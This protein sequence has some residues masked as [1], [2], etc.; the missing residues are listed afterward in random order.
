MFDDTAVLPLEQQGGFR[1][2]V[3]T[4]KPAISVV[5]L[6]YVGAV[7]CACL[8]GLG[9]QVIG[10]DIDPG[11][12][13]LIGR[14]E[15]PIHEQDLGPMLADAVGRGAL[16]AT[17]DLVAAVAATDVTFIS[18][19]TPTGE[20][21]G[22]DFRHL[23]A[24]CEGI[25]AA[26]AGKP[27]FHTVVL[28]CSVP[29]GTTHAR[30]GALI[31][32]ASGKTIGADFGLAFVPEFLRE[33]V[34]VDDFHNPP[35]TVIG[36][37]DDRT[38]AILARIFEAVD[39][40]PIFTGIETAE[41]VKYVDNVWH[42][43]KVC[44]G[45]EVGRLSKALDV[46]GREVMDVFCEDTKLN[47]SPAYL[48]PGFAYGGSCLPKEVRAVRTI[49][50]TAGVDLP[51]IGSLERSNAAQIDEAL[52]LV[53]AT[54]ARRVAVLGLAFKSGTDDLRESPI[55][56]VMAELMV[57][58]TGLSAHDAAVTAKTPIARQ[59]AYVEHG[60]PGLGRLATRLP[61]LLHETAEGALD[62]AEAVIVCHDLAEYRAAVARAGIP[63]IDLARLFDR[64]SGDGYAGIGW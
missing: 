2:Y 29:P 59:L 36:A 47:L 32:R 38:A 25:G 31:E 28:R 27:D 61:A 33:G 3:V 56:E 11:K 9:H 55:L 62:G 53:R 46:D 12:I 26:L 22:C 39:E 45:N 8:A 48:K 16:Q 44:F 17:A 6:G 23:D 52:R 20:D 1:P 21:G 14:G 19:G 41:L 15:A 35:K 54:K 60:A 4:A 42:A 51:L 37:S 5:G 58:G 57:E 40:A 18:V 50:G 7:S 43:L 63:V 64:R 49:A 34:A 10:V 30:I 24:A 13:E